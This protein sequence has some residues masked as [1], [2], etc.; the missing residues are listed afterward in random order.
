MEIVTVV[1]FMF[2]CFCFLPYKI[3]YKEEMKWIIVLGKPSFEI[4][5]QLRDRKNDF[6]LKI[7]SFFFLKTL[8]NIHVYTML[9]KENG[10][11]KQKIIP[12]LP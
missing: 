1:F 2:M 11:A 6:P 8:G 10:D 12:G 5:K 3:I 9:S 7:A 4:S